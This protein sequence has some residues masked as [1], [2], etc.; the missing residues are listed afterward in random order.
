MAARTLKKTPTRAARFM[1]RRNL[2]LNQKQEGDPT[3]PLL[4]FFP[5]LTIEVIR[6]WLRIDVQ[7]EENLRDL[8]GGAIVSPNHSGCAGFDAVLVADQILRSTGYVPR[9]LTY[10]KHLE[11]VPSLEKLAKRLGCVQASHQNAL[12]VLE[13]NRLLLLFPE[14]EE[15]SFKPSTRAYQL[16]RFRT[17]F[18]RLAIRTGKPIVPCLVI[19]AEETHINLARIRVGRGHRAMTLPLPLSFLPLPAK[20]TVRFLPPIDVSSYRPEEAD[21]LPRMEALAAQIQKQYQ[22]ALDSALAERPYIYLPKIFSSR[23]SAG[24]LRN[25]SGRKGRVK[26]ASKPSPLGKIFSVISITQAA[27]KLNDEERPSVPSIQ[28]ANKNRRNRRVRRSALDGTGAGLFHLEESRMAPGVCAEIGTASS[29]TSRGSSAIGTQQ[30]GTG[31]TGLDP[32]AAFAGSGATS[33]SRAE[34]GP[35]DPILAS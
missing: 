22:D 4:R 18:V 2:R 28:S 30:R 14:G 27:D 19:G 3:R 20:W 35:R 12:D 1:K 23:A 7:G 8:E 21:D 29:D 17:G 32:S 9:I 33:D 24:G 11:R 5:G 31:P 25:T 13:R 6:R 15:G 34:V 16:Q 26:A 10:W